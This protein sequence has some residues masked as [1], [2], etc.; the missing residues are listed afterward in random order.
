MHESNHV[1]ILTTRPLPNTIVN[2]SMME[3]SRTELTDALHVSY[4]TCWMLVLMLVKTR[5]PL[6]IGKRVAVVC[7]SVLIASAFKKREII[8]QE[9]FCSHNAVM[10][11]FK[12][13]I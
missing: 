5:Q 13:N 2:G 11:H 3:V 7:N 1:N 9:I 10:E 4:V 12:A 8:T 6:T